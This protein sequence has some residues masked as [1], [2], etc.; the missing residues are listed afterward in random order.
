M[1]NAK[2]SKIDKL[3]TRR[4]LVLDGA[5]GTMIQSYHLKEADFRG[6]RFKD[7]PSDLFGNNDLLCL[8]QP[9]IIKDIHKSFLDA[10]ADIVSTNTFN[11]TAISH[12]DYQTEAHVY[13]INKDAAKIAR[14][15]IDENDYKTPRFVAGSMGPTNKA[16]SMSPD[17]EN[18]GFRAVTFKDMADSYKTQAEGLIDG[19]ADVLLVETVFDTLNAKAAIYAIQEIFNEKNIRLPIWIS[20]TII[21]SSGRTLSGQTSEAFINSIRHAGPMCI[22]LNCAMGAKLLRPFLVELAK[23]AEA[24]ISVHPNAGLPDEL[25]NYND[26]PEYM[27]GIIKE[28]AESGLVNIVGG[29]CGTTPEHIKAIAKAV[30]NIPPRV[31]PT[32]PKHCRLS[33]LE[34]L[35]ISPDS[36]FINIGE[37]TNVAGSKKF[38][39]LIKWENHEAA[40]KVARDQVEKGAQIIDVNMD[41]AMLDALTSMPAF[42]NLI[43]SDPDISR[44]PVMIDSSDFSVIEA[45]LRCLQG[46]GIVNSIS[47]KDGEEEFI[48]RAR[49]I[50]RYGAA[51]VVMAFDEKGQA[52][53][54]E[55]KVEVCKRAYKVL[56]EKANFPAEDIIFDTN[57]LTIATGMDEHNDYGVAFI[58]A[59]KTLKEE[60]PHCL[61][62]GGISNL[63]FSFRGNNAVR[64]A[65]HSVFLY[66]AIKAGLDMGIVNAGQLAVFE[67]IP[68]DIRELVEDVIFN[69]RPDA[70]ARLTDQ[71]SNVKGTKKKDKT[72][73]SWR[74][75]T[76]E[77]RFSYALVNGIIDYIEPDL[78]E[79]LDKYKEAVAIIEG[80]LMDGM[81]EVG[82]LFGAGKMFLP[83]V[84]RSARVM[85]KAVAI[86]QP[87]LEAARAGGAKKAGKIVLATVKGDVHDIGKNITRIV[88]ECNNYEV[89][90]LGV[91]VPSEKILETAQNEKA[92]IIGLSGLITPSL[93]EMCQVASEM[94]RQEFSTPLLI[95]GATTS[96]L[97][98]AVKIEP[99][100]N[101]PLVHVPDAS[102]SIGVLSK[103][104]SG[105]KKVEYI[106]S[107]KKDYAG[108]RKDRESRL[109]KIRIVTIDK[110]RQN[111]FKINWNEYKAPKPVKTGIHCFNDYDISELR[112]YIDWTPFFNAFDLPGR[113]PRILEVD[114]LGGEPQRLFDDANRILD[115]IVT[116]KTIRAHAVIGLFPANSI[117]EDI[118]IYKDEKRTEALAV[119]HFLRQQKEKPAGKPNFSLADFI[120]P[121]D[122]SCKD[123]FGAFAVS[124]G[125]GVD[126]IC[127]EFEKAH[128]DYN[129]IIFRALADRLVEALAERMHQRV[130]QEFWGYEPPSP[131][132]EWATNTRYTGI[133][134]APGYPVCPDHSE[135]EIL[136]NLLNVPEN[137]GVELTENYLM[138][139]LASVSGWYFA[140]PESSYFAV[141]RIGDDQ[142]ENY[143]LRKGQSESDARKWLS[144][145]LF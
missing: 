19:G 17:V 44:V 38:A 27:A 104:M 123:Y 110:A 31:V 52:V 105:D 86:L 8:T 127:A 134:P 2:D 43:A 80:P 141:G 122:S 28:F 7:H 55:H 97:H 37:R 14:M 36:L 91:M 15:A 111:K 121:K 16:C 35:T 99:N 41:D 71:A 94:E 139:P 102:R 118:E 61:F 85:K 84:I 78:A 48:R 13:E 73:L 1:T 142:V 119:F 128:D 20:G 74:R 96:R 112:P 100:Y 49:L 4:I 62:S 3:L 70:T 45:G 26:D 137:I 75:E 88:M 10:G 109:T 87:H 34:P 143:S 54:Y 117:E 138:M 58:E 132:G 21:D 46:K 40:M 129:S 29:C 90:D 30:S 115:D 135:K 108:I 53:T 89:V 50:R 64:E 116:N 120:A 144:A 60:L 140:L 24:P 22:G 126:E 23:K 107:L 93:E 47:L 67:E 63:S 66:Y 106:K 11:G 82:D 33:G 92:D 130:R 125:F 103:L 124:A 9:G 72:D 83:Q 59:C 6:E 95:G 69:R 114:F 145:N 39:K 98:T 133:R 12:A 5:M 68:E 25:G 56:T 131:P 113:Y 136:F 42:L 77:K 81:N 51:A 32:A 101:G 65:M 57:I 18:P 79:A 76:L